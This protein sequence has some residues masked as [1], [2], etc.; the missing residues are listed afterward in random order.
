MRVTF[1]LLAV[2][3]LGASGVEAQSS[4]YRSVRVR[5]CSYADSLL[6]PLKDD[7]RGEVRSYYNKE[8]DTTYY[9]AGADD[10]KPPRITNSAKAQGQGP[11]RDVAVQFAVFLRGNE[12]Q[13]V[14]AASSKGPVDVTLVLDDSVTVAPASTALGRFEG[15]RNMMTLPVS[16]LLE[17]EELRRVAAAQRIIVHAGPLPVAVTNDERRRLRALIRVAVCA[18]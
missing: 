4:P 13:V 8:R 5:S 18:Q 1:A 10:G 6:G 9:L 3:A 17:G 2:V 7:F 11:V 16:A 12:A 14:A 15:P